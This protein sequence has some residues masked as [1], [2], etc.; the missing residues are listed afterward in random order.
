M[1]LLLWCSGHCVSVFHLF[2]FQILAAF[3]ETPTMF[4]FRL[5][6]MITRMKAEICRHDVSLA[7]KQ[8]CQLD[9]PAVFHAICGQFMQRSTKLVE[10][11]SALEAPNMELML[12]TAV[13]CLQVL[14]CGHPGIQALLTDD[15][16]CSI[17]LQRSGFST[18]Y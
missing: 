11:R 1:Y 4:T 15:V 8:A 13:N 2:W 7:A 14:N 17:F 12:S 3:K 18:D 16:S 9:V 6:E 10:D 5:V